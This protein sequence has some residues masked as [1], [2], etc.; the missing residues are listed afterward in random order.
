MS[1]SALPGKLIT[2][3]TGSY[4]TI[5]KFFE[6]QPTFDQASKLNSW[7]PSSVASNSRLGIP[8]GNTQ[9]VITSEDRARQLPLT[10]HLSVGFKLFI[11]WNKDYGLFADDDLNR[12]GATTTTNNSAVS[13]LYRIGQENRAVALKAWIK[14]FKELIAVYDFLF[15]Q[16]EGL[17]VIQNRKPGHVFTEEDKLNI[18][19]RETVDMRVQSLINDYNHIW[20]DH[21]RGVEVLPQNLREFDMFIMLY[22]VNY[23]NTM[24][25]DID[26]DELSGIDYNNDKY[27]VTTYMDY[28]ADVDGKLERGEITQKQYDK[29]ES[30]YAKTESAIEQMIAEDEAKW[31]ELK[32]K[33]KKD[34]VTYN[35]LPTKL[36]VSKLQTYDNSTGNIINN[37]NRFT[38][39]NHMIYEVK[40]CTIDITE[41]GKG[42]T[43]NVSNEPGSEIIKNN[44]SFNYKRA[45]AS[46]EFYNHIRFV[47]TNGDGTVEN[48]SANVGDFLAMSSIQS[49]LEREVEIMESG[50]LG[51][52]E[53]IGLSGTTV[54]GKK[55]VNGTT[56][57]TINI[58]YKAGSKLLQN[59]G[60]QA[61][62]E[63]GKEIWNRQKNKIMSQGN[64]LGNIINVFNTQ[65]VGRIG[66][67]LLKDN[68][69]FISEGIND[70]INKATNLIPTKGDVIGGKIPSYKIVDSIGNKP[71]LLINDPNT[72]TREGVSYT[73]DVIE[74]LNNQPQLSD[75][76]VYSNQEVNRNLTVSSENIYTNTTPN[77]NPT[78]NNQ[79]NVYDGTGF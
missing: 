4:K 28:I 13:Y 44:I 75:N 71:Q 68:L 39:F 23:Y 22:D 3:A 58:D 38:G 64:L 66:V 73:P 59:I 6:Q 36:K 15:M 9:R 37:F 40:S 49:S 18:I 69:S 7:S 5:D 8:V 76:N 24:L 41:T 72:Q 52:D 78:F 42:F 21:V 17:E 74:P 60:K 27:K 77:D 12:S 56:K 11:N 63:L 65:S 43:G 34:D 26:N 33:Y 55:K 10:E 45:F 30:D 46:G 50:E 54:I 31:N 25:Y 19:I 79:S 1:L 2:N 61:S 35:V 62:R 14:K 57:K 16:V 20:Y 47:T 48:L 53:V 51:D 29:Y 70:Q 67:D 32:A